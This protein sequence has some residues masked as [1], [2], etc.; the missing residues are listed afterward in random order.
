MPFHPASTLAQLIESPVRAGEVVWIG[1]RPERRVAMNAQRAVE[2]E[3]GKGVAGDRYRNRGGGRQVTLIQEESLASIASHLGRDAVLPEELRRNIV[4]RGIN[5]L[6]LKERR[7]R[8]GDAIL[9]TSGECHPC[10]KMEEALGVGGYNAMRGL[11]GITA[12]IVQGGR[13]AIGDGVEPL[14][15]AGALPAR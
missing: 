3:E 2:L 1:T 13:V 10:S 7:F 8:I 6:A 4:V 9:E 12:R 5:L 14:P 11:G 15:R